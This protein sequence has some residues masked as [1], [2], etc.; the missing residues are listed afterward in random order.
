MGWEAGGECV[1]GRVGGEGGIGTR[2]GEQVFLPSMYAHP[3]GFQRG[4]GTCKH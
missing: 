4:W 3:P 1:V 2:P